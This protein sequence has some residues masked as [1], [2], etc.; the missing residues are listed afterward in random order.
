MRSRIGSITLSDVTRSSASAAETVTMGASASVA[1]LA[2]MS[3][4]NTPSTNWSARATISSQSEKNPSMVVACSRL[5]CTFFIWAYGL[6]LA[7]AYS[8][9]AMRARSSSVTPWVF[10]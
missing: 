10:M 2:S 4:T 5:T 6:W 8:I 7:L 3:Q 9:T 1:G